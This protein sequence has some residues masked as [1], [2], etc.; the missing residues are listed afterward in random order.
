MKLTKQILN[1][2]IKESLK[3]EDYKERI[4]EIFKSGDREYAMELAHDVG[5]AIT[6]LFTGADL[7][8]VKMPN[9][10]LADANLRGTNFRG[11]SLWGINMDGADLTGANLEYANLEGCSLEGANLAG[12]KL[13]N[14]NVQGADFSNANLT[15][16]DL[17]WV[18]MHVAMINKKTILPLGYKIPKRGSVE[19]DF[20]D[21]ANR[22]DP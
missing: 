9:I 10:N 16:A 3:Q 2:I 13:Y 1:K 6:D 22:D 7:K 14:A 15:G 21:M 19:A 8:G 4:V 20:M 11:A 12:A 17:D 5:I 18:N